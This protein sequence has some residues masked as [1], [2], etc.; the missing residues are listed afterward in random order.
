MTYL[1]LHCNGQRPE[2]TDDD[3]ACE[4]AK[5]LRSRSLPKIK[6]VKIDVASTYIETEHKAQ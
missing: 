6:G 2:R 4:N 1:C 5:G 3:D